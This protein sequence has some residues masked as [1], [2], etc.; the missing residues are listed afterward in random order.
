L[1]VFFSLQKGAA[2]MKLIL[3]LAVSSLLYYATSMEGAL[4]FTFLL[5]IFSELFCTTGKL[6][7]IQSFP[8]L[9]LT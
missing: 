6:L 3:I 1:K 5:L 8:S 4:G 7:L 2:L 9:M